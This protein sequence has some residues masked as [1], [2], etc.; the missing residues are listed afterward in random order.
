MEVRRTEKINRLG[1]IED[2]NR[3]SHKKPVL[4]T[5]FSLATPFPTQK[6]ACIRGCS[7]KEDV[8]LVI[9]T[10]TVLSSPIHKYGA[11]ANKLLCLGKTICPNDL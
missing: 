4:L 10:S 2:N 3:Y 11:V 6:Q 8:S 5:R 1:K 7:E 9:T